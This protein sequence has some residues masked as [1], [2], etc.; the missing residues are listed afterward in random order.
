MLMNNRLIVV[1]LLATAASFTSLMPPLFNANAMPPGV[2]DAST[3]QR[4]SAADLFL[5]EEDG[6][7]LI[8][9]FQ[10][11]Q[12]IAQDLNP[13]S[14]QFIDDGSKQND[15]EEDA[16]ITESGDDILTTD[17]IGNLRITVT[18]TRTPR[19]IQ[20][21]PATISVFDADD[22]N[23]RLLRNLRDLVQY[24]PGVS[25]RNNLQFGLCL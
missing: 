19:T 20:L 22:I 14:N 5:R 24:E 17:G 15:S 3:S 1:T 23:N 10:A 16:N 8:S 25:V 21:S 13:E 9:Q 2:G 4:Y 12:Q 7:V 18:G 11:P 6:T